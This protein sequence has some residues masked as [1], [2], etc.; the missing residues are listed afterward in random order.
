[1][2]PAIVFGEV[3]AEPQVLELVS[4][5]LTAALPRSMGR[6]WPTNGLKPEPEDSADPTGDSC[7]FTKKWL[8]KRIEVRRSMGAMGMM[9]PRFCRY[10]KGIE[11]GIDNLLEHYCSNFIS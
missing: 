11:A 2:A 4:S 3:G 7:N 1:M 8:V 10:R 9:A 6:L 5:C